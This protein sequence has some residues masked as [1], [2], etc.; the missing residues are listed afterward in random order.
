KL[1][2]GLAEGGR[3]TLVIDLDPQSNTTTG[4]G[5]DAHRVQ[6]SIYEVLVN[7]SIAIRD[8]IKRDIRPNL[9]LLPAK[10]DL[11][12]ADIELV[13]LDQREFRLTRALEAVA[14]HYEFIL[15]DCPSGLGLLTINALS[16]ADG[17]ILPLR[18]EYFAL[19]G[20]HWLLNAIRV[21]RDQFNPRIQLFGVVL[22][23]FDSKTKLGSEVVKEIRDH[24]PKERFEAIIPR[25]IRLE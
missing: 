16:A 5:V 8:A 10:V 7:D 22:T 4:L 1:E 6:D 9:S 21:V 15:I 2:G 18:C 13:Y 24:F 12:A 23:T 25:N 14:S 17:V 3:K 19:E 11:Y 20:M